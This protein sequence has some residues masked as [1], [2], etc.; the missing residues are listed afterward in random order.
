VLTDVRKELVSL[1]SARDDYGVVLDATTWTVD[2]AA[3]V[4]RRADLRARRG[5][6][7]VPIVSR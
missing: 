2:A 7:D 1:A 6:Q 4:A 5:W 3:T